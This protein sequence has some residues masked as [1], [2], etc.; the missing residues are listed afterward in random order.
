MLPKILFLVRCSTFL[1]AIWQL[2][3]ITLYEIGNMCHGF[4]AWL[5]ETFLSEIISEIIFCPKACCWCWYMLWLL[6]ACNLFYCNLPIFLV[7]SLILGNHYPNASKHVL[8]FWFSFFCSRLSVG[9]LL[10]CGK[11]CDLKTDVAWSRLS[12]QFSKDRPLYQSCLCL[13]CRWELGV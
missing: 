10:C 6:T 12:H 4:D 3:V 1:F 11:S 7:V 9:V 2:Y 8:N 13:C 5:A